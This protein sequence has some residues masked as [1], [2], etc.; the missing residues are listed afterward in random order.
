[1]EFIVDGVKDVFPYSFSNL[2]TGV[3]KYEPQATVSRRTYIAWKYAVF[4]F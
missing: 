3:S 2:H 1:M 4:S